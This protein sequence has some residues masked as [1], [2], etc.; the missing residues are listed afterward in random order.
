MC[1]CVC[2]DGC[3]QWGVA[4]MS[5]DALCVCVCVVG[6]VEGL[7]GVGKV[8]VCGGEDEGGRR[9]VWQ[10]HQMLQE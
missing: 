3:L 2:V 8:L 1:V 9:I 6:V 7:G 10:Y 5:S 4:W